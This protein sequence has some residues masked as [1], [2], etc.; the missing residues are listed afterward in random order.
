MKFIIDLIEDIRTEIGNEPDFT[1]HAMLLKEDVSDPQNL[2]YGG[3][4]ALNS[5]ILDEAGRRLMMRID[6]SSGVLTIGELIKRILIYDMDKM[7]YE[8]RLNV[9]RHYHDVEVIGF[10]KSIEEK[11][12]FFFIK[13]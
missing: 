3:E 10:G 8:V 12:Y 5:F 13:L 11:R 2:I 6:G 1:V 4:A 9:N 7:M